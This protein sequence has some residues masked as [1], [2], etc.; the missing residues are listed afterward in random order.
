MPIDP[1]KVSVTASQ[2]DGKRAMSET[3]T[4]DYTAVE[5]QTLMIDVPELVPRVPRTSGPPSAST[6]SASP[7]SRGSIEHPGGSGGGAG[8][9]P[10]GINATHD[11][12]ARRRTRRIVGLA[13][14]GVGLG[15][16]AVGTVFALTAR[17][18]YGDAR[19]L[20]GGVIDQCDPAQV[21]GAQALVDDARRSAT[22]S[23]VM[24]SA[25]GAA[26]LAGAIVWLTAPSPEV[27]PGARTIVRTHAKAVVVIPVA[28]S[29][30]FGLALGSAF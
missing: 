22:L 7:A 1:G 28:G 24:F 13:L 18:R 2:R 11:A 23:T 26:V 17:S 29:G 6:A 27:G 25:A 12:A 15:A 8:E 30:S 4:G 14:G 10:R 19:Q 21:A 16:A 5:G 20:C 3:W 9:A